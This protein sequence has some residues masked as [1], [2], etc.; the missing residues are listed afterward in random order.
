MPLDFGRASGS[1]EVTIDRQRCT[2]CGLCAKVCAGAPLTMEDGEVKVD[3][4]RWFGCIGC[5][6]CVAVCPA[7]CIS[8]DGR[9]LRPDDVFQPAP[10]QS[11]ATYEQLNALMEWRR[12]ARNFQEREVEKEL[13]DKIIEAAS[14]APM[15]VPPSEVGVLVM[16]GR[17]KVR[18]I[19]ADLLDAIRSMKWLFSPTFLVLMRPIMGRE[20]YVAFKSFVAPV[21]EI[22][23]D[24]DRQGIDWFFH[25]APLAIYF[26][27]TPFADPADPVIAAT[28]AMLAAESLGLG[29]CML[30]FPGHVLKYSKKLKGK[31]GL[32]AKMQPGLM[33]IAGYSD[34][35]YQRGVKRRFA[36]LKYLE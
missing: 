6:Q 17:D 27:G 35:K 8:I 29:T 11:K 15:G 21:A 23:L 26:Y 33:L 28:H 10:M 1:A 24:G 36:E 2:A 31:Y 30:G 7:G 13:V 3:Q 14:T 4:S 32:P 9:D 16:D 18:R 19:R 12:S 22:Y 34:V 5:G 20:N 25:G